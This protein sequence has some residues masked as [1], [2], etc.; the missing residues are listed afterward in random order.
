MIQR[1]ENCTCVP[2]WVSTSTVTFWNVSMKVKSLVLVM[3][4]TLICIVPLRTV[5]N[6][7]ADFKEEGLFWPQLH[8]LLP[9]RCHGGSNKTMACSYVR[10]TADSALTRHLFLPLH[11]VYQKKKE[12]GLPWWLSDEESACQ[13][14]GQGRSLVREDPTCHAA[15]KPV[16]HNYWACALE[17]GNRS[18]W[19]PST[20]A[21]VRRQNR[22]HSHKQSVSRN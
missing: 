14:R 22:S 20:A 6:S 19:S 10:I 9:Q 18:Y 12:I 4:V 13:F 1:E 17:P 11:P 21:P 8:F 16:G 7:K 2:S 5:N 3:S 15:T